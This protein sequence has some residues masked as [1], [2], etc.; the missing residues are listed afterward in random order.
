MT[1]NL[2]M[3]TDPFASLQQVLGFTDDNLGSPS[4]AGAP[5]G[6]DASFIS[7]QEGGQ[8]TMPY[9]VGSAS[10][11]PNAGITVATGVDLGAHTADDLKRW[12]VSDETIA[13]LKPYL[14]LKGQAALD[15]LPDQDKF[16]P[17]G[18]A[19]L[20]A[21]DRGV[22][23]DT[24]ARVRDAYDSAQPPR[25]FDHWIRISRL[26]LL[27]WPINLVQISRRPRR[28]SGAQRRRAI[29]MAR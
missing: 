14:G 26:Q 29:G 5:S 16:K 8:R 25:P 28:N 10:Q 23:N 11:F 17:I 18:Q 1:G 27:I 22:L 2:P 6:V 9:P 19:D 20:D 15:A 21:M 7:G 13:A 24:T 3:H 12:G 4:S